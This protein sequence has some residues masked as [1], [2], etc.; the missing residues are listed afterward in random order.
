MTKI[1]VSI[2]SKN[3]D[4][5][6]LKINNTNADYFHIDAMDGIFVPEKC[7]SLDEIKKVSTKTNKKLDIHLMVE[8]PN[9]YIENLSLS[10]I[11]YLTIHYEILKNNLNIINKI[12]SKGIKCGVSV[13]PITDIKEVFYLLDTIDLI[14]IMSVEPG[15]GGQKFLTS[16]LDKVRLLRDEIS[17]RKLNTIISI[18]GGINNDNSDLCKEAGCDM[19][20]VGTYV[21]NSDDY[22][23][24][25]D[26]I[27]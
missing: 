23:H 27:R 2:L 6:I 7:F 25:I 13:K 14:L 8:N 16:S 10:N 9:D 17:R 20:V 5:T 24:H 4:N 26:L 11:E 15:Y 1:S 18:D 19:L 22:Q 3:D 12:K 21:V